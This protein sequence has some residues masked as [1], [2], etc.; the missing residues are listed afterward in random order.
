MYKKA[1][2]NMAQFRSMVHGLVAQARHVMFEELLF[3]GGE[4]GRNKAPEIPW[5]KLRDDPTNTTPGWSFVDD[6]RT[7]WPV[8]SKQ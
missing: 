6:E 1:Q 4:Y 3:C 7:K 8:D 5:S 2:F